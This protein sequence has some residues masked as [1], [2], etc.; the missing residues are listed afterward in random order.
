M[1]KVINFFFYFCFAVEL[2]NLSNDPCSK[3]LNVLMTQ[4]KIE[5]YVKLWLCQLIAEDRKNTGGHR[6]LPT[7]LSLE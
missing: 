1:L 3:Y 6:R 7:P 2:E 4:P 5:N